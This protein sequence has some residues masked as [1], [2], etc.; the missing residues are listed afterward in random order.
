MQ[1]IARGAST[2]FVLKG[3]SALLTFVFYV[4]IGRLLGPADAG[5]YF[6]ALTVVTIGAVVGRV[7]LD[8]SLLRFVAAHG[9]G[10]DWPAV[11]GVHDKA[12]RMVAVGSSL[13]ALL[14][15]VSASYISV[16][17]FAK[18][19]LTS[20][21]RWMA[22]AIVPAALLNLQA[23][24]LQGLKRIA[25]ST[26]VANLGIPLLSLVGAVVL[27]PRWGTL[28]AV[29]AYSLAAFLTMLVG[30]W[31]WRA[32][33]TELDGVVGKF[34][35]SVLLQSSVPLFWISCLQLVIA[36]SST[37]ILGLL[38]SSADVGIYN[39]AYRTAMLTSFVLM[40]VNSISAPKFAA[41]HQQGDLAAL[42]RIARKSAILMALLASP[43]LAAFILFPARVMGLFGEQFTSGAPVLS[44]LAVGQFI[45]VVT[46]SVGW[47]LIMCG[48]ERL[49]RNNIAM[50]A[51]ISITLNLLLI[52]RL[53]V[54][55]AAIAT[56]ATLALQM[57]IGAA[58]VWKKLGLVTIPF[59]FGSPESS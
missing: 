27:A 35:T 9:A 4:A 54:I 1:E 26:L 7:G 20:L 58:L 53:G 2:A 57:I 25:D 50:C 11:K 55:G 39:S 14:V 44:I 22:V 48:Y 3:L 51:V 49:M 32:A 19:A 43:I 18:P 21:L 28:G 42:G 31:R 38:G 45:N 40:A 23:L 59:W 16:A 34:D 37:V 12:S 24:G 46:G 17:L 56:A 6:L 52:P 5:L 29:W 8:N 33:T 36:S 15:A 41:L 13:T 30:F 47:I 10:E